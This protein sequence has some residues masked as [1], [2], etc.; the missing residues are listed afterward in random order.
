MDFALEQL[1][2]DYILVLNNDTVVHE[3]SS[4]KWLMPPKN[5]KKWEQSP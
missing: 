3:I 5:M 1:D 2:P 4:L